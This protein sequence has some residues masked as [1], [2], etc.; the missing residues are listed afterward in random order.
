M[1]SEGSASSLLDFTGFCE[2]APRLIAVPC[3]KAA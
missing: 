3:A 1:I 2:V